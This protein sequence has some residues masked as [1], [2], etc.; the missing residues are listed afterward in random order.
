MI[1]FCIRESPDT[2]NSW[3]RHGRTPLIVAIE[4]R[5]ADAVKLLPDHGA[6]VDGGHRPF[7]RTALMQAAKNGCMPS[8][9]LLLDQGADVGHEDI[10]GRTALTMAAENGHDEVLD[11]LLAEYAGEAPENSGPLTQLF[12]CAAWYGQTGT[13]EH[14]VRRGF[15]I[16]SKDAS[17]RTALAVVAE[18]GNPKAVGE[19]LHAGADIDA[20]DPRGDTALLTAAR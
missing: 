19:L 8:V 11:L 1:R 4:H 20:E 5:Q 16:Q 6:D 15:D 13:V 18:E 3:D 2:L 10:V 7:F 14:L 12:L 9:T 17:G